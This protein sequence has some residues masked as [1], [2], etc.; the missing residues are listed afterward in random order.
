M[1]RHVARLTGA[2]LVLSALA[3]PVRAQEAGQFEASAFGGVMFGSRISLTPGADV[4]LGDGAAFGL[5]GA[6]RVNPHFTLE[7]GWTHT[8]VTARTTVPETNSGTGPLLATTSVTIDA[9]EVTG[10]YEW[11]RSSA[12][13]YFGFGAGAMNLSDSGAGLPN[14]GTRF[15]ASAVLGTR[16]RLAD[17]LDFR[18]EG[19][20]RWR[21]TPDRVSTVLCGETG[22]RTFTTTLYTS[23]EIAAGLTYRFGADPFKDVIESG[24]PASGVPAGSEKRFWEAAA[25]VALMDVVPWAFNR[26]V[27]DAEFAHI[28]IETVRGNFRAGFGYDRDAFKTNQSS[29]PFHGSLFFNA[30]RDNGYSFWESGIFT[31][32]GSFVWEQTLEREPP[33][34]NDLVNTTLGGMSRGEILHRLATMVL[35]NKASGSTRFWR[36]AGAGALDPMSFLNRLYRG[37]V[38]AD[39]DNPPDRFPSQFVFT[40]DVGYQ[41]INGAEVTHPDQGLLSL[42]M[43]YGNPWEGEIKRPYDTFTLRGDI[44]I[45]GNP[46]IA[47]FLEHR[48]IL[49]GWEL[50][51]KTDANRH[52]FAFV[53]DYEYIARAAQVFGAQVLGGAFLS[54]W[55]LSKA[56]AVLTDATLATFPLAAVGTTDPINPIT[57]RNYDYGPGGGLRVSAHLLT[58]GMDV[59]TVG[60]GLAAQAT[61]DGST[62]HNRMQFFRTEARWPLTGKL[63][64]GAGWSWYSLASWYKVGVSAQRTQSEWRAFLSWKLL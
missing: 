37:E 63:G 26:Y 13:G 50:T 11:G 62:D 6:Y 46:S 25:G 44:T 31:F 27:S 64:I 42:S 32:F 39:F 43:V 36:E 49:H 29:H 22:C 14:M 47:S 1:A 28:S 52:I 57:G 12:R 60:Y 54:R 18:L 33:A 5:R 10:L 40:A 48:G 41:G 24:N 30:A 34:I 8:S 20:Y 7:G 35:D 3:F 51:E 53:M 38:S 56:M 23:P 9:F 19:R 17:R 21:V 15:M 45:P 58:R 16:I 59:L 55:T 4:R 61:V 2:A